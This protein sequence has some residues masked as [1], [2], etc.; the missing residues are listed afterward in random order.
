MVSII[1]VCWSYLDLVIGFKIISCWYGDCLVF[2][3]EF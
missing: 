1:E 2:F 3:N